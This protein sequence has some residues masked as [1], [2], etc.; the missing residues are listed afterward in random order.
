MEALL[1]VLLGVVAVRLPLLALVPVLVAIVLALLL[2]R[3]LNAAPARMR[4]ASVFL[5]RR[6][7]LRPLLLADLQQIV[8]YIEKEHWTFYEF[9]RAVAVWFD[10]KLESGFMNDK[11]YEEQ[12]REQE[13]AKKR[14]RHRVPWRIRFSLFRHR[15]RQRL[16]GARTT[17]PLLIDA[18]FRAGPDELARIVLERALVEGFITEHL[19]HR[20]HRADITY[21]LNVPSAPSDHS[22]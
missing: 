21:S 18:A 20:F 22:A 8:G 1:F 17:Q 9:V 11:W 13:T 2:I 10:A 5:G 14:K 6:Y 3:W 12:E 16:E 19:V 7:D 15:A 4:E